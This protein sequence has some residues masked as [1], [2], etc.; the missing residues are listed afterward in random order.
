MLSERPWSYLPTHLKRAPL[1]FT[2]IGVTYFIHARTAF[3]LWAIYVIAQLVT[4]QQRMMGADIADAAWRDQHL[5]ASLIYVA[6]FIWVGRVYWWN[7]LKSAFGVAT[8]HEVRGASTRHRAA[9]LIAVGGTAVM[10][11][12]LC[13]LRVSW[14]AALLIVMFLL[15]PH[16]VT[17][18][19]V[20]ETGICF[21]RSTATFTEVYTNLSPGILSGRDVFFSGVFSANG[22]FQTREGMLAYALHGMRN[23]DMADVERREQSRVALAIVWTL[24]L[25][26]FVGTWS[27]LYCYYS[28]ATPLSQPNDRAEAVINSHGLLVLPKEEIVEPLTRYAEGRFPPKPHNPWLHFGTGMAVT[29]CLQVATWRLGWWPFVPV[30]Y[31]AGTTNLIA[32]AWFSLM[33]GW[34]AKILI[35]RF[36]GAGLFVRMRPLFIG[37]IFGEALA[38]GFWLVVNLVLA[39][40]GL[41]Y[42]PLRFLP[43]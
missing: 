24:L 17:A 40:N 5:G 15:M 41:E 16:L 12:W 6:G 27:S 29:A 39:A 13:A 3:S 28:Y 26:M 4:G 36:G 7:L 2:F 22:A 34:I 38:A 8:A 43:T 31:V 32:L 21:I 11:A 19:I 1:Y 23:C 42:E 30:G 25:G 20:A 33:I 9:L 37:I 10:L 35:L 14:W 18:R